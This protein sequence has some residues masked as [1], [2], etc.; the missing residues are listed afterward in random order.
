M[1][2]FIIVYILR[3]ILWVGDNDEMGGANVKLRSEK[4]EG[5]ACLGDLGVDIRII[6]KLILREI[7]FEGADWIHLAQ[8]TA[9]V[10]TLIN[11]RIP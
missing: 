3:W 1:M 9:L 5:K 4:P 10:D 2:N 8:D 7:E 6:L 11:L